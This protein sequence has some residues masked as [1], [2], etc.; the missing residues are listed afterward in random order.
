MAEF[1]SSGDREEIKFPIVKDPASKRQDQGSDLY[2]L[3]E[4]ELPCSDLT[5]EGTG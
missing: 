1:I 3:A 2:S 4:P 5:D